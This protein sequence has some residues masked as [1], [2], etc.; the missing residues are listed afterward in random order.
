MNEF[1]DER[2]ILI[3]LRLSELLS[4]PALPDTPV[5]VHKYRKIA[6]IFFIILSFLIGA[7]LLATVFK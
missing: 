5:D 6:L 1:L 2:K 3:P 7:K 4:G